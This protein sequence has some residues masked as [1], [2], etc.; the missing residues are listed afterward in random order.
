MF[1]DR[2]NAAARGW[3]AATYEQLGFQAESGAWRNYYLAAAFELREGIP[4]DDE[5]LIGSLEFLRAVPTADLFDSLAVRFDP[6]RFEHEPAEIQFVFPDRDEAMSFD[7]TRAVAFP[8]SGLTANPGAT[9]QMDRALFDLLLLGQAE[10]PPLLEAGRVQI[11]GNGR[12][13][14]AFLGALDH[15]DYWFDVVTPAQ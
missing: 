13:V 5:I 10:L 3:L 15:F 9:V 8:R 14:A 6:R 7:I 2:H 4:R 1:A 11:T 12:A